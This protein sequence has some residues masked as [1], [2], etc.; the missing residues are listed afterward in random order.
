MDVLDEI[1]LGITVVCPHCR[2]VSNL[3]LISNTEY[4]CQDCGLVFEVGNE[5]D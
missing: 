3:D 4:R 5:W 2:D 1:E